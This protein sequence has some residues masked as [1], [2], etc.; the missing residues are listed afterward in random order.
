MG[1]TTHEKIYVWRNRM[2]DWPRV[3]RLMEEIVSL[4][5]EL[6]PERL[7]ERLAEIVP[8]FTPGDTPVANGP[9]PIAP[10]RAH[11]AS[12]EAQAAPIAATQAPASEL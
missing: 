5:D 9:Q 1:R 10:T 7:K 6:P 11:P 12:E 2:E 4:A 8:E 3:C